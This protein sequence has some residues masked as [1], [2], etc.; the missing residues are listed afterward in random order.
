MDV[1]LCRSPVLDTKVLYS[2][3]LANHPTNACV[4]HTTSLGVSSCCW[5]C[6]SAKQHHGPVCGPMAFLCRQPSLFLQVYEAN[7]PKRG[8]HFKLLILKAKVLNSLIYCYYLLVRRSSMH[9]LSKFELK[10]PPFQP[11]T[12]F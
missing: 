4:C 3:P 7:L 11:Q 2:R 9:L 10:I 5:F 12:T 1:L 6:L 8:C